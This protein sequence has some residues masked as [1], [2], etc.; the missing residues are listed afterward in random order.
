M[1]MYG[2]KMAQQVGA[3]ACKQQP[4]A[5]WSAVREVEG[6]PVSAMCAPISCDIR[7]AAWDEA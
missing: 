7:G 6:G 2:M 5:D 1:L 3:A 4:V